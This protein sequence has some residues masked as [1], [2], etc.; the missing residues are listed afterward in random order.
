MSLR[1]L[2][3]LRPSKGISSPR[4][5]ASAGELLADELPADELLRTNF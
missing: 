2:L 1:R 5:D 3:N 4:G